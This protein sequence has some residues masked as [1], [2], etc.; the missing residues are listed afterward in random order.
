MLLDIDF[1]IEP[2][3]ADSSVD[4]SIATAGELPGHDNNQP[5]YS[6]S[7]KKTRN[8]YARKS[9]KESHW[10][11]EYLEPRIRDDYNTN[12]HGRDAAKFQRLF[13][14]PYSVFVDLINMA[15][16]RWVAGAREGR[17]HDCN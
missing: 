2:A 13:R 8:V 6:M 10:W 4:D 14:N 1:A 15:R 3:P 11:K 5:V 12:P 7:S 17:R 9:P 16:E